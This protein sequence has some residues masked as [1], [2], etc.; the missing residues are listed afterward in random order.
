[1]YGDEALKRTQRCT[2]NKD[3]LMGNQLCLS[4]VWQSITLVIIE[5]R[6]SRLSLSGNMVKLRVKI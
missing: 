2:Y 5:I 3:Q 1:M 4:G 6:S